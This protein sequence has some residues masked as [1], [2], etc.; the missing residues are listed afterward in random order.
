[1]QGRIGVE[2]TPGQGSTFWFE[3]P[4]ASAD[5]SSAA[6]PLTAAAGA[7]GPIALE[8]LLAEDNSVSR[9]VAVEMLRHLGCRVDA[10][11]DGLATLAAL[12]CGSYDMVLIDVR[13][14]GLD[15]LEVTAE[16]RRREA[17]TGGRLPVIALTADAM[18][19][20]RE[21]CLRAG[22]DDYLAKPLRTAT[23]RRA[24]LHGAPRRSMKFAAPPDGDR[25]GF[26]RAI[27]AECCGGDGT[28]MVNVLNTFLGATPANL[29]AVEAAFRA[30]SAA[31]LEHEAH[32]LKGACHT[33]GAVALAADCARLVVLAQQRDLA[34]APP[35]LQALR[36]RWERVRIDL[37]DFLQL[38]R[39]GG[40]R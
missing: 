19:G 4:L 15:G 38:L 21:R 8:V 30:R 25:K 20:D 18:P 10:V 3:L 2:S 28:L 11:G 1:M 29:D 31:E 7:P 22:M 12:D 14:P 39:A 32:R 35:A 37:N 6:D 33:V 27:L 5:D 13:L 17:S 40:L 16:L 23:L 34:S 24:L 26:D 9:Q 36:D